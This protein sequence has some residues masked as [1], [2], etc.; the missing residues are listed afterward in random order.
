MN[1]ESLIDSKLREMDSFLKQNKWFGRENETVNLFAH[2]F[3][4]GECNRYDFFTSPCQIGIEV[5][6]KQLEGN[7]RKKLVRKDL[8]IWPRGISTVWNENRE[9]EN[10]PTAIIEWKIESPDKT[11]AD[12]D[13]LI[14]YTQKYPEILGY[15]VCAKLKDN[16]GLIVSK[17]IRGNIQEVNLKCV[18]QPY[19]QGI[20]DHCMG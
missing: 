7:N 13:W 10:R 14:N 5:S 12:V 15:S 17:I 2:N 1:W 11:K 8:V 18:Y 16:R 9:I 3:L 6:V 19:A 20:D 4:L